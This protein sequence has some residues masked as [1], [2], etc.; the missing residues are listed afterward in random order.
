[1]DFGIFL[2]KTCS[3]ASGAAPFFLSGIFY[4]VSIISVLVLFPKDE[5]IHRV[6]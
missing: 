6:V 5:N 1:M 3:G 2:R 4:I